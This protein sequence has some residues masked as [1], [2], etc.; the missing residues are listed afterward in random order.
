MG[1][2]AMNSCTSC[3]LLRPTPS[4]GSIEFIKTLLQPPVKKFK[5]GARDTLW[6]S[7]QGL[8]C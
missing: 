8:E 1:Q 5:E 2:A 7:G 3:A 4:K 6:A